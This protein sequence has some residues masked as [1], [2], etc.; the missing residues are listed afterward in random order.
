MDKKDLIGI[1][2]KPIEVGNHFYLFMGEKKRAD[3]LLI[4]S[5]GGVGSKKKVK[6]P[7][8]TTLHFYGPHGKSLNDPGARDILLGE[9]VEYEAIKPGLK[10]MVFDYPLFRLTFPS[11]FVDNLNQL[12]S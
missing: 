12:I 6:I 10:G 7:D 8:W 5:H 11:C 2:I 4:S 1:K 3:H 9:N